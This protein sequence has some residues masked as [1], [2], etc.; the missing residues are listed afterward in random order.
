MSLLRRDDEH[1]D[2][3]DETWSEGLREVVARFYGRAMLGESFVRLR[4]M[5]HLSGI[6]TKSSQRFGIRKIG[7][8]KMDVYSGV[9]ILHDIWN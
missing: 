1:G 3:A 4:R 2:D 6:K 5:R 8:L 9:T 7:A